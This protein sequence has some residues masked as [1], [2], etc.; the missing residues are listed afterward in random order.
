[1]M[2][3]CL[4]LAA[5]LSLASMPT[6]A[7]M[8]DV[9]HPFLLWTKE[10]AAAL[11]QRLES[12]PTAKKQ[13]ERMVKMESGGKASNPTMLNL[14]KY[15]ALGDE[16]AGEKEKAELLKCIGTRP[17]PMTWPPEQQ[18][19]FVWNK[20]MPSAGD[21]HMRD[22]RTLY[23]LRYD[24]LYDQLTPDE[25]KGIEDAFRAYIQFHLAGHKPW[26][27]DFRYDRTS[28]LP[29]MHWPRAIGT[30]L[31]AV[32]LKDEKLIDAMFNAT[33]GWKWY[34][35]DYI[36]DGRF[37]NEEFGK[38]YSNIGTMLLWC[39]SLEKLGLGQYGYGYTGRGG[40]TM[41]TFLEMKMWAGLPRIENPGGMPQYPI[42]TMGDA[43]TSPTVN[44]YTADGKGGDAWWSNAHMN[45]PLPKMRDPLW[46][47]I[48]QR[49]WPDAHFDYFLA[50]MRAPGEE[51]YLPSLYFGLGLVDPKKVT[52]PPAPSYV[53]RERG[54]ALLRAEESPAYWESPKPVVALQFAMR[55]VHYVHDC[56]TILDYVA[57]NAPIYC[58]MG[59]VKRGYAGSDPWRDHM[60]GMCGVVVDG[61][62][63]QPVDDGNSG[64]KNQRIR[65]HFSPPA[66][67][68]AVRAKGVY[69]D[70]DMERALVLTSEYLFDL[71]WLWSDKRRVYDWQ[72]LSP[73]AVEGIGGAPWKPAA[74]IETGM[75]HARDFNRP[76][77]SAIHVMLRSDPDDPWSAT[78]LQPGARGVGVRVSML[79]GAN[80]LVLASRPPGLPE[81]EPGVS[82]L[83]SRSRSKTAF[84]ALHEPFT[85]GVGKHRVEQ[86]ERIAQN[87]Q[88]ICVA[89]GG[90]D[91][92][93]DRI[94]L[95]YGDEHDK[96]LTLE[97][98]GESFTFSDYAFIR[99][100]P[101]RVEAHGSLTGMKLRVAGTPK[102]ILNGKEAQA[103]VAGGYLLLRP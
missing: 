94:L 53:A 77:L 18:K 90:K 65:E 1:M 51:V 63:A 9:P 100:A 99:I 87:D 21:R 91:G 97:G 64:T 58:R 40:A 69:P 84:V 46:W 60:R 61:L 34:F 43:G 66:K 93:N 88:G 74:Q 45:G 85:G 33:G 29:N 26:H 89:I 27:P 24:A 95:R 96:P 28:W 2:K 52:P 31:M 25:R 49:R 75:V 98:G 35:D 23:T 55:Y 16:K 83:A 80:T 59:G 56:F 15:L 78:I 36:T 11:R 81:Q 39:E 6:F 37:Y 22:E 76:H 13:Y 8:K 54:F 92:L 14:F 30:H 57:F 79:G 41:R 3:A 38:Y 82:L 62:Q 32:A 19:N 10:E 102:L 86:S 103:A 48:G 42:V 47:E 67:F 12:D 5:T 7:A 50:Q 73:G 71:F 4:W 101:D 17:E 72:I 20:G 44:G 70:V 68:V